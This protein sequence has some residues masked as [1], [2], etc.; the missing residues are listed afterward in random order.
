MF[1]WRQAGTATPAMVLS[2]S[3]VA[4]SW[5]TWPCAAEDAFPLLPFSPAA[6]MSLGVEMD[7]RPR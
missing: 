1:A 3:M 5:N 6:A 7:P 2:V 4:F